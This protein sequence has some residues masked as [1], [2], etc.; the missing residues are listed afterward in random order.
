[1]PPSRRIRSQPTELRVQELQ[2]HLPES[3]LTVDRAECRGHLAARGTQIGAR[4][5]T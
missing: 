5:Q 2:A 3:H 4:F 1:M